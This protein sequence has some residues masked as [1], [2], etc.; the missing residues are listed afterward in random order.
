MALEE[1]HNEGEE[2]VGYYLIVLGGKSL[3]FLR[4]CNHNISL[5]YCL[6]A[7]LM[8]YYVSAGEGWIK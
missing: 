6:Y 8:L 4:N 1:K 3:R 2:A 7:K 5:H